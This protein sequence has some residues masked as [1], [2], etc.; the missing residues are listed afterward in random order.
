MTVCYSDLKIKISK[1]KI[2][3]N[4]LDDKA[5][6]LSISD[7]TIPKRRYPSEE[8]SELGYSVYLLPE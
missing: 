2:F 6:S 4:Y 1:V 8:A 7:V 3:D 5:T